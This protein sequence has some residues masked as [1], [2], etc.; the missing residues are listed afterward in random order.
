MRTSDPHRARVIAGTLAN[1]QASPSALT[2]NLRRQAALFAQYREQ[3]LTDD[4]ATNEPNAGEQDPPSECDAGHA[5]AEWPPC[6]AAFQEPAERTDPDGERGN[7]G[8]DG[9]NDENGGDDAGGNNPADTQPGASP[10][11][12][13]SATA[14]A[15]TL[16]GATASLFGHAALDAQRTAPAPAT[17]AADTGA[18]PASGR[19]TDY[20]VAEAAQ[21]CSNPAVLAQGCWR[22]KLTLDP[23][24]V[25]DCTLNLTL[26]YFDLALRFDSTNE[27]S[28]QLILEHAPTLRERLAEVLEQRTGTSRDIAITVT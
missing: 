8:K 14:P 27:G 22:V 4:L 7:N 3:A 1:Q 19:L 9:N 2:P 20:L 16:A 11:A 6:F 5:P 18:R 25:P 15:A 24:M 13:V 26:S 10:V 23:A 21:L 12:V 17:L 28:R